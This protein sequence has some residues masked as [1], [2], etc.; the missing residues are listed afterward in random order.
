MAH[1]TFTFT[2]C[3]YHGQGNITRQKKGVMRACTNEYSNLYFPRSIIPSTQNATMWYLMRSR[4]RLKI[5]TCIAHLG[6]LRGCLPLSKPRWAIHMGILSQSPQRIKKKYLDTS[7]I[8][9]VRGIYLV[10]FIDYYRYSL[11][12]PCF[13]V[14]LPPIHCIFLMC[15]SLMQYLDIHTQYIRVG[16]GLRLYRPTMV[17]GS[18]RDNEYTTWW[19][20][21]LISW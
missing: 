18:V 13:T 14:S 16:T 19:Y 20:I 11:L 8:Y 15:G 10:F 12:Q 5:H 17:V 3:L 1:S 9:Y 2:F 6:F 4:D 21:Y 7:E